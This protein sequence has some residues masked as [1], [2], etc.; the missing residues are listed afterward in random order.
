MEERIQALETEVKQLRQIW[1]AQ[2]QEL[3]K[4][5]TVLGTVVSWLPGGLHSEH[6]K[7]LLALLDK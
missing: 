5:H 2:E 7:R 6:V 1:L 3:M 4:L